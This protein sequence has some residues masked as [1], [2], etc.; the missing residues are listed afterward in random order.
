MS[1]KWQKIKFLVIIIISVC[2]QSNLLEREQ[3]RPTHPLS[4]LSF[5]P[6][7]KINTEINPS[8]FS[9]HVKCIIL[10]CTKEQSTRNNRQLIEAD[11]DFPFHFL[12]IQFASPSSP[13]LRF[14]CE[15]TKQVSLR[16]VRIAFIRTT[17]NNSQ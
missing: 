14:S 17:N 8:R 1:G 15:S 10:C 7:C 16:F 12:F 6:S 3:S 5:S 9:A 4:H 13:Y 2:L 11:I